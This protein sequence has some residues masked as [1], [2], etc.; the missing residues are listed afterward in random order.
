MRCLAISRKSH[1]Q[2]Y[3]IQIIKYD[4]NKRE[5]ELLINIY[6]ET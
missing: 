1:F 2:T 3:Q 6:F 5:L 4:F